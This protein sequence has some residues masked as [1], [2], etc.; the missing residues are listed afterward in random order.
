MGLAFWFIRHKTA[1][2]NSA[3]IRLVDDSKRPPS[4]TAVDRHYRRHR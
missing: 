2:V 3:T 1:V 4:F